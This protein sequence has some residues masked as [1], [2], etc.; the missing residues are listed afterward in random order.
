M[1][2]LQIDD[3]ILEKNLAEKFQSPQQIKD[4][5]YALVKQD[6]DPEKLAKQNES[7]KILNAIKKGLD[8]IN[9]NKTHSIEKLWDKLDC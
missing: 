7:A 3:P 5:I 9:A 2:A 8:D 1:L 4:Y 6:L